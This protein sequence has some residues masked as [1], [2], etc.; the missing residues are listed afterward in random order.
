MSASR[1][2]VRS[3]HMCVSAARCTRCFAPGPDPRAAATLATFGH[4]LRPR[5]AGLAVQSCQEEA[6]TG[7]L[8]CR[9]AAG[10]VA[11]DTTF[12]AIASGPEGARDLETRL[13]GAT[14][15]SRVVTA[16]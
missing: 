9:F 13:Q 16:D 6:R 15:V 4:G 10:S 5:A 2:S 14:D 3:H 1:T 8:H 11:A 12:R 7:D